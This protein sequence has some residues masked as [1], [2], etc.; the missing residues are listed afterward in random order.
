MRG[1]AWPFRREEQ[2][3]VHLNCLEENPKVE[4]VLD[5]EAN[6]RFVTP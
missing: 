4:P 1:I 2:P 3:D 5:V 6:S